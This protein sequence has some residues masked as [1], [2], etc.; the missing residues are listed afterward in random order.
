MLKFIPSDLMKLK[1]EATR[2]DVGI[3]NFSGIY[4]IF[5]CTK[6][7]YYDQ[8][9][10]K[11]FDRAY[12]HFTGNRGSN[13]DVYQD[14]QAGDKFE[15]SL[16]PIAYT[17]FSTLNE[18]EGS[19][20]IAYQSEYPNGYNRVS[21]NILDRAIFKNEDYKKAADLLLERITKTRGEDII[22]ELT[23]SRKRTIFSYQ[24]KQELQLPDNASFNHSFRD[25]LQEYRMN[26][27]NHES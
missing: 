19:A 21:G 22:L 6:N 16:I 20:I 24:L 4:L 3:T 7:M 14:Y 12:K 1:T 9:S 11:I 8:K 5:N 13:S 18:L 17:S 23:N 15:I 25:F 26:I 10:I 27:I 2:K